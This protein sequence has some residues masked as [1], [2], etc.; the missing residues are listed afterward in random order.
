MP[1][2]V[3]FHSFKVTTI[4]VA[5]LLLVAAVVTGSLADLRTELV[6]AALVLVAMFL[7]VDANDA[8]VG[9]ET[10]VVFGA[11]V[12]FHRPDMVLIAV[13]V[14]ATVHCVVGAA[15]RKSWTLEPFYNAAQLALSYAIVGL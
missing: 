6:L 8:S 15:Q 3:Y 5:A 11:L 7:R 12:V 9:F 14:G 2:S 4:V 10:A 1:R 13:L